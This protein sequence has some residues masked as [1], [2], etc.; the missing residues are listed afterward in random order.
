MTVAEIIAIIALIIGLLTL[1]GLIRYIT[2]MNA[3]WIAQRELNEE[4]MRWVENIT[5]TVENLTNLST[6]NRRE[7]H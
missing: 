2:L 1:G 6:G 7:K 3:A 5:Q 4:T